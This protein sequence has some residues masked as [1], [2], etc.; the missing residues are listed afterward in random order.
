MKHFYILFLLLIPFSCL[1][2]ESKIPVYAWMGGPGEATDSE[3]LEMFSGQKKRGIDGL[4]PE[5]LGDAIRESM[6]NGA[7]GICLFT[8]GRM[9]DA[10]WE[11]LEKAIYIDYTN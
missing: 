11:A 5:E 8:P 4:L 2:Q 6:E 7:K 3:L 1:A 10:H 9:T